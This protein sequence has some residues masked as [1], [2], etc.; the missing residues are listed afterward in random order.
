MKTI[1]EKLK[2][3]LAAAEAITPYLNMKGTERPLFSHQYI[4]KEE[5][6]E[7]THFI[8]NENGGKFETDET[9]YLEMCEPDTFHLWVEGKTCRLIAGFCFRGEHPENEAFRLYKETSPAPCKK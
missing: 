3:Y 8:L 1:I 7:I 9:S 2:D 4:T 5:L 6:K